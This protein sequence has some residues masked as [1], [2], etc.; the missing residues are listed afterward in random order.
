MKLWMS[1][2]VDA[3]V[4][5]MYRSAR[6]DVESEVN[7]LL[8]AYSGPNR[9]KEWAYIAII[10]AEDHPDYPEVAKLDKRGGV[11]EFRLKVAHGEFKAAPSNKARG[12]LLESLIRSREMFDG[13]GVETTR[14]PDVGELSNLGSRLGWL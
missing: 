3:D 1:A 4:Y 14:I 6:A 11:V 8:G 2:E 9:V 10:R 13:L 12:M 5:E 7:R